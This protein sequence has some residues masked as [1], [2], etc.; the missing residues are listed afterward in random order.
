VCY[1]GIVFRKID[2]AS[3]DRTECCAA[4]MFLDDGDGLVIRGDIGPWFSP[5][6]KQFHLTKTAARELLAKVLDT[7]SE[8]GG[9]PLRE[10]FLHYRA[11]ISAQ[12]FQGFRAACPPSTDLF[13]VRLKQQPDEIRLYREGKWPV[14]RGTFLEINQR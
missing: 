6:M 10:I 12:E 14:L 4:Q 9:K 11:S 3:G 1:V 7:Y 2:G 8:L 5:S 13:C